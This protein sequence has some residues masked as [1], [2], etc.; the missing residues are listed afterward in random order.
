MFAVQFTVIMLHKGNLW[1]CVVYCTCLY[2]RTPC[3]CV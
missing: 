3:A 2:S 1:L